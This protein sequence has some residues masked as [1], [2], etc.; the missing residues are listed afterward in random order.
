M[1]A[2][3][4]RPVW[5]RQ[6]VPVQTE[7]FSKTRPRFRKKKKKKKKKRKK[8]TKK[9]KKKQGNPPPSLQ[10]LPVIFFKLQHCGNYLLS[11]QSHVMEARYIFI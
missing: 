1:I 9:K 3:S 11:S 4:L 6:Q 7:S 5:S 8:K 10:S 2:S